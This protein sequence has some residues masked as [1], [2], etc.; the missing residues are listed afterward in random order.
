MSKTFHSLSPADQKRVCIFGEDYGEAANIDL[1]NRLHHDTLPPALSGQNSY[2]TWWTHGCDVN[3]VI[4]IIPDTPEEVATK[5]ES[6]TVVGQSSDPYSMP[7]ERHRR[8]FLLR[9]RTPT[10][11]FHWADERF[12]Y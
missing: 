7:F 2:W 5:Y 6:V 11:P 10:A 3:L 12:Y 9:G 4:A 1:R 8:I